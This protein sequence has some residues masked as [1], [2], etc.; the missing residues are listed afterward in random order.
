V[1]CMACPRMPLWWCQ[2]LTWRANDAISSAPFVI[3]KSQVNRWAQQNVDA[4]QQKGRYSCGWADCSA[5]GY[6]SAE[7]GIDRGRPLPS[8]KKGQ[9]LS[10]RG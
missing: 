10:G 3:Y 2:P 7:A 1:S 4:G 6:N 5:P 9:E 8:N